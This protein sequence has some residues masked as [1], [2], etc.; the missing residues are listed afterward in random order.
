MHACCRPCTHRR[1]LH[2]CLLL[3]SLCKYQPINHCMHQ[4][5]TQ[6][7]GG[8]AAPNPQIEILKK[9]RFCRLDY[10]NLSHD[11]P[12]SGNQPLVSADDQNIRN[13]ENKITELR[14]MYSSFV[15]WLMLIFSVTELRVRSKILNW[16]YVMLCYVIVMLRYCYV[17]LC[18]FIFILC[19]CYVMLCYVTLRY[20][21]LRYVMLCYVMLC[22]VM[23]CYV[24]LCYVML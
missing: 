15:F 8:A 17:M 12:F 2:Y 3:Q 24:M 21:M 19:Y 4:A 13:L 18:Y 22:Y 16:D 6:G 5:H 1:T 23:L 20:V 10:I 7:G 14:N 9:H 11:L